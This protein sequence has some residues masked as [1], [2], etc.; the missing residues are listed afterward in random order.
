MRVDRG[1]WCLPEVDLGFQFPPGMSALIQARLSAPAALEAMTTG[2]R[3]G[4]ADAVAAGLVTSAVAEDEVL[5]AATA[6]VAQLTDKASANL[7]RIKQR[8]FAGFVDLLG[9]GT[10]IE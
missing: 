5:P 1:F 9:T 6:R 2:R 10:S 3:Y 7:G 4:G 8:M